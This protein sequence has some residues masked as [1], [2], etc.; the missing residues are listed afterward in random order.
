MKQKKFSNFAQSKKDCFFM[1]TELQQQILDRAMPLFMQYGIKSV[2]MDFLAEKLGMSKRT[3]YE[4]FE[5]KKE[6]LNAC[7]ESISE[8]GEAQRK[9]V[10]S[11]S[12]NVMEIMLS[13]YRAVIMFMRN[14]NPAFFSDIVRFYPEADS[15]F[16]ETK[17]DQIYFTT[18]ILK[19]GVSEGFIRPD[20]NFELVASHLVY[21]MESVKTGHGLLSSKYTFSE[22]IETLFIIFMRGIATAEGVNFIDEFLEKFRSEEKK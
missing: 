11:E 4:N 8:R 21:N 22:I 10:L 2:T 1:F 7:W 9:K 20:I 5:N 13:E 6:L 3:L 12:G 18:E 19:R 16:K 14:A 15:K 17:E